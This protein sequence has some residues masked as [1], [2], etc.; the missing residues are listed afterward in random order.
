MRSSPKSAKAAPSGKAGPPRQPPGTG[1]LL[2]LHPSGPTS[3]RPDPGPGWS[4]SHLDA[5]LS[6]GLARASHRN[7]RRLKESA[8]WEEPEALNGGGAGRGCREELVSGAGSSARRLSE[9]QG[10]EG[11]RLRLEKGPESP[12]GGVAECREGPGPAPPGIPF[13]GL[14]RGR[15]GLCGNVL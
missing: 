9:A 13:P 7:T 1:S 15:G 4:G 6:P 5:N 14:L 11:R 3:G 10:A 8:G 12:R 2:N